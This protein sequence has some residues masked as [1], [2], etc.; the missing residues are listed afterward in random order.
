MDAAIIGL[1]R[2]AVGFQ[3]DPQRRGAVTHA[4][5]WRRHPMTTLVGGA[6]PDHAQREA[7]E[8]LTGVPAYPTFE[9]LCRRHRPAIVSVCTPPALHREMTAAALASGAQRVLCEKPCTPDVRA[10]RALLQ[11]LGPDADKIGVNFHRRYDPLHRRLLARARADGVTSGTGTYTA[12]LRNTASHWFETVLAAGADIVAVLALPGVAG[13]DPTPTAILRLRGGGVISL[14]H[15]AV[16]EYLTYETD[17][18]TPVSR[19]RLLDSGTR[20]ELLT[21]EASPR[22]AGY[23]E[24]IPTA[25]ALPP[26]MSSAMLT[27]AD[28]IVTSLLQDRPPLCTVADA[29]AVHAVCDAVLS[30]LETGRWTEVTAA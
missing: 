26:G 13:A 8:S 20:G 23:R 11:D 30:S 14:H 1:G 21:A 10:A 17:L 16:S 18:F 6:D 25:S 3:R 28:D 15:G 24:L 4:E 22:F 19:V 12:G 5:A 27:V 29:V 2:I 9:E 7:F